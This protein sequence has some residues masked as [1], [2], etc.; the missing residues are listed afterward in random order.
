MSIIGLDDTDSRER[1][2]CTTYLATRVAAA[3]EDLGG[4]VER[5]L[6]VRLNPAVEHKTRGNAALAL[7]VSLS[8]DE[9]FDLACD[10]LAV[11]AETSDPRTSPGVV[12]ADD[13][14]DSVPDAVTRFSRDALRDFHTLDAT[15]TLLDELGYRHR[16]WAGGRGR[17]GALAAVGAWSAFDDWT[18]E[19][20]S[21]REFD[22]CGTPRD[23]DFDTVFSA[24]DAAYPTAWDT[25]DHGEGQAVCVPHAPGPILHGIRGDDPETVRRVAAGIESEPVDCST[26]FLTN[27]GTDAHLRDGSLSVVDDAGACV[28][29]GRAFRLDA[30]VQASPETRR[31]GHVFVTVGDGDRTLPCVA[32]EPTKRFRDRVRA[33]RP[34]DRLTVCGELADGTLKLEKFAVRE[35][36]TTERVTPTCPECGRTMKSAGKNQGYRCRDCGTTEPDRVQREVPRD[37]ERG[38]YEVPPCA[39][40]HIAKP[41][42]RGGFDAP[43]HPER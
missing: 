24:A 14:G 3:V 4:R 40:R 23:I 32:F 35:L 15:T 34:G 30:T 19:H 7:H 20:I 41:L 29:D 28:V 11:L 12:V 42:I 27:Q 31:G 13:D 2:M 37:L 22:R 43:V 1:G 36:Q 26:T 33:L 5:R 25:V 8:A 39:R 38:W 6:L 9:A 10:E 21:Y 16:G 18:F 17:I